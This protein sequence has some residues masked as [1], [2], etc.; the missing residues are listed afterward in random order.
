MLEE[1]LD[2]EDEED[3]DDQYQDVDDSE[4]DDNDQGIQN[5]SRKKVDSRR[6]VIYEVFAEEVWF[7]ISK[8]WFIRYY[9]F[10][11]W[12]EIMFFIRGFFEALLKFLG[13]L[14][15]EEYLDLG[16][17]WV[18]NFFGEREY[19]Y[20]IFKKYDYF[21]RQKFLFDEIDLV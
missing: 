14:L 9:F 15:K 11:I 6:E 21:K 2:D 1:G 20:D 5:R 17:K 16:R 3:E 8:K 12:M 19:I 7:R 4:D 13:Y 18:F 10:L